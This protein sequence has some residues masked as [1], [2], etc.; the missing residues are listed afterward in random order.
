METSKITTVQL[1]PGIMVQYRE[2]TME[3]IEK[4][5]DLVSA[6][7]VLNDHTVIATR[8]L[9][10]SLIVGGCCDDLACIVIGRAAVVRYLGG[11]GE[12]VQ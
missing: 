5:L 8:D 1:A 12:P 11:H 4:F 7:T 6:S 9:G 3:E 10:E 2:P